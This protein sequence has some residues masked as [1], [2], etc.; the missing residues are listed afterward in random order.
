MAKSLSM[1]NKRTPTNKSGIPE[2][3]NSVNPRV[4]TTYIEE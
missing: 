2:K 3:A 1:I 4:E